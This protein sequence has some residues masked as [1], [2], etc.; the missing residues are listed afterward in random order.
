MTEMTELVPVITIDGPGG[1]GKGTIGAR[2]AN[3][4]NWE[5]LDSG[6]LY[7][8]VGLAANK[9]GIALDDEA[10]LEKISR[11]LDAQFAVKRVGDEILHFTYLEDEDVGAE[12][13][14]E[15]AGASASK[16]AVLQRVREALLQR[17]RDFRTL[18]GLVCDGRD[19]GTVVFPDAQLK[20]YLTAS[21]KI[22]AE[23]RVKQLKN[24]GLDANLPQIL[25]DIKARDDRD[26]NRS[27]SPLVPADDAIVIDTSEM[28]V[29]E[30]DS[31][32]RELVKSRFNI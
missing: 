10:A 12:L 21:A 16:V 24:K 9:H 22:R 4:L 1:S 30:V 5:F 8:L 18:P 19:M 3:R 23:R 32:I 6:A 7:R 31:R 28:G 29:D 25:A 15:E 27:V 17:Q 20:I 14:T 11:G 13:R 2:L 26:M